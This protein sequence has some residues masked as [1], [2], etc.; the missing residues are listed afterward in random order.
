MQRSECCAA[1]Y[2]L[3]TNKY[4][5][6]QQQLEGINSKEVMHIKNR[7]SEID[8]DKLKQIFLQSGNIRLLI[9]TRPISRLSPV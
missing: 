5:S 6:Q 1:V 3:I 8:G 4:S 7:D 2:Q 9:F